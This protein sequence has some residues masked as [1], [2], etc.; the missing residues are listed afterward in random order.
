MPKS[1]N[2]VDD[3]E[4]L[5]RTLAEK[6]RFTERTTKIRNLTILSAAKI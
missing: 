5:M 3:I 4:R 1:I 6:M 2:I